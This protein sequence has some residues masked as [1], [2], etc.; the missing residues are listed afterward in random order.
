MNPRVRKT[1]GMVMNQIGLPTDVVC[2]KNKG[3]VIAPFCFIPN[4]YGNYES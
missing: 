4:S 2:T 1:I 3:G